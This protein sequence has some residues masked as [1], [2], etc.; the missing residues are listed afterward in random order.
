MLI[1]GLI[2]IFV[3]ILVGLLK[4]EGPV[5]SEDEPETRPT[6]CSASTFIDLHSSIKHY[7]V[8][9]SSFMSYDYDI[10]IY[11]LYTHIHV[12]VVCT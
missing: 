5:A 7:L 10:Y 4:S 1:W 9:G 2:F 8:N 6:L 3:T 11:V 12:Y